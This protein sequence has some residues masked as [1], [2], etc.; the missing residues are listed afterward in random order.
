MSRELFSEFIKRSYAALLG[1][2][3]LSAGLMLTSGCATI[4]GKAARA[5][6]PAR[7]NNNERA[8]LTGKWYKTEGGKID[9]ARYSGASNGFESYEIAADGRI[10]AESLEVS[11]SYDCLVEAST[12]SAGTINFVPGTQEL[13]I[14]L[15]AGQAR[16]TN[17]CSSAQNSTATTAATSTNYRWQLAENADGSTELCLTASDGKT[18]CYRRED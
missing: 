6:K 7:E 14:D 15:A 18:T 2:V 9:Y 17:N 10:E 1:A 11:R 13:N 3:L 4:S 5:A 12:R 8:D 16:K